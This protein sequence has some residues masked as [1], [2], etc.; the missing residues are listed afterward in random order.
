LRKKHVLEYKKLG[1][2][3]WAKEKEYGVQWLCAE[4]IFSAVKRIFGEFVRA[5]KRNAYHEAKL[6]FWAYNQIKNLSSM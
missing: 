4:R 5:V 3:K 6:K 1:Y 2:K